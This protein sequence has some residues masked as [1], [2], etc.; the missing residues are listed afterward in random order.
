MRFA[1]RYDWLRIFAVGYLVLDSIHALDHI[2]QGRSLSPQIYAG[3][4]LALIGSAIVIVLVLRR[5]PV[6]PLAAMAFGTAASLG[7]FAAH[8][9]PNFYYL[10]DSY[11]PLRLDAL[12]WAIAVAVILDAAALAI[13]GASL[14][15]AGPA[16]RPGPAAH[17]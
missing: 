8:I 9:M 10:S 6:A 4:T 17:Q 13:A 5:H 2:R 1:S 3:G 7:V 11:Q 14:V 12:S 16:A 15:A